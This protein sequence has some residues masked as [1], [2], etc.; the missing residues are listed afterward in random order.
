DKV[1]AVGVHDVHRHRYAVAGVAAAPGYGDRAADAGGVVVRDGVVGAVAVGLAA[2]TAAAAVAAD[3]AHARER[4]V[5]TQRDVVRPGLRRGE[6]AGFGITRAV[7][8]AVVGAGRRLAAEAP[9]HVGIAAAARGGDVEVRC[10]GRHVDRVVQP[11]AAGR[12]EAG[13]RH[14]VLQNAATAPAAAHRHRLGAGVGRPV[15]V[16]HGQRHTVGA[17]GCVGL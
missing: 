3:Q 16:G 13:H 15:I 8:A 14:A 9:V 6:A 4:A 10:P 11:V 12:R 1:A 17:G 2:A 7:R 5:G